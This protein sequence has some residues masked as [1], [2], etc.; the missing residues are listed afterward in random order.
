MIY[1]AYRY[2]ALQGDTLRAYKGI[3]LLIQPAL[4]SLV[5]A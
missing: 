2:I 3:L 1:V 5:L 4:E